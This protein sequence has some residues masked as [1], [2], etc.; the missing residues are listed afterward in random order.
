MPPNRPDLF[1]AE[2]NARL[3]SNTPLASGYGCEVEPK[4]PPTFIAGAPGAPGPKRHPP[5]LKRASGGPE[6]KRLPLS[7]K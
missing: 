5:A 7:L 2:V 6:P 1:E 4:I 3:F